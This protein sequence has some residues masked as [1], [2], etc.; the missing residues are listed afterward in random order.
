MIHAYDPATYH[1]IE[2]GH[3]KI[4][5]VFC[6]HFTYLRNIFPVSC[7]SD[8]QMKVLLPR[9]AKYNTETSVVEGFEIILMRALRTRGLQKSE[10]HSNFTLESR[11]DISWSCSITDAHI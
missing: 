4:V 2:S 10:H 11:S 7:D 9:R 8:R 6:F 1:V 3:R 5:S